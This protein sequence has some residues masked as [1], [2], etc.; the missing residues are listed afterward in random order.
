MLGI[1]I[2]AT[3]KFIATV[4]VA[5]GLFVGSIRFAPGLLDYALMISERI[6]DFIP[7]GAFLDNEGQSTW[8][9]FVDDRTILGVVVTAVARVLIESVSFIGG[10]F[11]GRR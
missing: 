7:Q 5:L 9:T 4:I 3:T 6:N 8:S 11:G 2:R 10:A 1:P